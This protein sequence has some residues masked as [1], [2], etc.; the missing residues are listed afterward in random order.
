M[1]LAKLTVSAFEEYEWP[2]ISEGVLVQG[3]DTADEYLVVA[4][5]I[6]GIVLALEY[7]AGVRKNGRAVLA[8]EDR[9]SL[10][11]IAARARKLVG[12]M[13]LILAEDV[14]GVAGNRLPG[15][16]AERLR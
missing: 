11:F 14:D 12:H 7:H 5:V 8:G 2:L 16:K 9:Q 15:R 10:P 3:F 6:A 1:A 13:F 4:S